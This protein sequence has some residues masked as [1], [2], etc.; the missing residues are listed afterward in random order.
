VSS[1]VQITFASP[2]AAER[3]VAWW[4]DCGGE[5]DWLIAIELWDQLSSGEAGIEWYTTRVRADSHN[6][7]TFTW[8]APKEFEEDAETDPDIGD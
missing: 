3:F 2:A 4:L 6:G 5:E 7:Y 8:N 1:V